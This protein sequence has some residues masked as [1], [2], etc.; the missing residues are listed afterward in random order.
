MQPVKQVMLVR[1]QLQALLIYILI[2][3]I[4]TSSSSKKGRKLNANF[5]SSK[6]DDLSETSC[7]NALHCQMKQVMED[8]LCN[9]SSKSQKYL[10]RQKRHGNPHHLSSHEGSTHR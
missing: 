2:N 10:S 3:T 8:Q 1:V 6:V 4:C 7:V 5:A 9:K